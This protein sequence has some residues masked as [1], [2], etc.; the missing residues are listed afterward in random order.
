M[1]MQEVIENVL[2]HFHLWPRSVGGQAFKL[3]QAFL[4]RQEA[5]FLTLAVSPA[6]PCTQNLPP[7]E[8]AIAHH[9][10]R[11]LRGP[12]FKAF[13]TDLAAV[14]RGDSSMDMLHVYAPG[15]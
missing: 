2:L 1:G 15:Q 3:F 8:Q 12:R 5:V 7:A 6:V 9:A 4:E 10:F 14:A 13:M 11:T